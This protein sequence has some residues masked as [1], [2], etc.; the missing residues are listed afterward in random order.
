MTAAIMPVRAVT[1]LALLAVALAGTGL[2]LC[3]SDAVASLSDPV[4]V[5]R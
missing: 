5:G 4:G 3:H 1:F 2:P